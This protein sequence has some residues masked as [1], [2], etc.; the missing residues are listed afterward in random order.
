MLE[1]GKRAMT[2]E[3]GILERHC[4]AAGL[5]AVL[6]VQWTILGFSAAWAQTAPSVVVQ[7]E[8]WVKGDKVYLKDV[9][10]I[11]GASAMQERLGKIYLAFA[12]SPG[13]QKTLH[14]SWIDS[15]VRSNKWLPNDTIVKIPDY[16][17][18]GRASQFI[19]DETLL[20]RYTDFISPQLEGQGA[21]FRV[22]RFKVVG[23]GPIPE[24]DLRVE[25]E[26]RPGGRL[27]GQVR[28]PAIV[29]VNEKQVRRLI[30]SGWVDRFEDVVCT[31]RP[32]ERG[33][34]LT[35]EDL[36]LEKRNI[37]RLPANVLKSWEALPGKRLKRSVK[38]GA[39]LLAN[40]V[41]VPP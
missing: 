9:A 22:S 13:K 16:V 31:V 41:E 15:K 36:L 14:G 28:L 24:G 23:N 35:E 38:E 5:L 7:D 11:D 6:L 12:P 33:A 29:K 17:R 26:N 30:L 21:D 34:I 1:N 25:I 20:G 3:K 2:H 19:E 37:S 4:I 10:L 27:S 18:V 40:A 8:T 39:V 32:L